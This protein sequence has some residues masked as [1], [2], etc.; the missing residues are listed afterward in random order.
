MG[1][2]L[3]II[4]IRNLLFISL[5]E[6]DTDVIHL[7]ILF[8]LWCCAHCLNTNVIYLF[9][10]LKHRCCMFICIIYIWKSCTWLMCLN[11]AWRLCLNNTN[12]WNNKICTNLEWTMKLINLWCRAIINHF[13]RDIIP[14][15]EDV[16]QKNSWR[17]NNK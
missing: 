8:N 1:H 4:I 13:T 12:L 2:N 14:Y 7:F 10:L 9:I 16:G 6:I 15:K 11:N 5:Y 3:A 17:T